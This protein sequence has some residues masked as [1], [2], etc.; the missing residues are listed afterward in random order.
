MANK[1]IYIMSDNRSGSTLL[2]QLLGANDA[3]LSLGEI[4]H[5][6][7]YASDNRRLYDPVHPLVCSCL[8]PVSDCEFWRA[9]E[10]SLGRP[11]SSLRLRAR[12]FDQ[13]DR[14]RFVGKRI[15]RRSVR[16]LLQRR[17]TLASNA[18]LRWVLGGKLVA[19][20]SFALYDAVFSHRSERL[21]VDSSKSPLRMRFLF[22]QD[23]SRMIVVMLARD[24]RGTVHSKMKRG[25][26]LD[27]GIHS[28]AACMKQMHE[29]TADIPDSQLIRVRYEDICT[30]P[31]AEMQRICSLLNVAYDAVMLRRPERQI[32]HLGGSPSKFD[33]ERKQI[34]LDTRYLD[35]FDDDQLRQMQQVAGSYAEAWGYR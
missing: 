34:S 8:E 31:A 2:D 10:S 23:P 11:L 9:T 28:W 17:P 24:Y 15:S 35:A 6:V 19:R 7:A 22:D 12:L 33:P 32:H 13:S 26:D 16:R 29:L 1:I 5:L 20:D 3:I 18:A 27:Y 30:D 14:Y 25:M 4:Q 21:I